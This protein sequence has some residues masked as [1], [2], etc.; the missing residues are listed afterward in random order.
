MSLPELIK[1]GSREVRVK[2]GALGADL[3]GEF[4]P[5]TQTI[6]LNQTNTKMQMTET[7]WHELIHAINDFNRLDVELMMEMEAMQGGGGGDPETR[8]FMFE[9]R[10]TEAFAGTF[11]QVIKDN[12]LL[13]IK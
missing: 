10:M 4:D 9:E 8:A 1:V 2:V 5:N 7:F 12:A 11:L 3:F 6:T 13:A